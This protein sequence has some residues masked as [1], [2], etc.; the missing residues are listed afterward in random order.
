M[1]IDEPGVVAEITA[2]F[3]RYERALVDNDVAVL[4]AMF[5]P[6]ARTIRYG[7][8][9]IQHGMAEVAAFRLTQAGGLPRDLDRTVFCAFGRDFGT[10]TTLFRRPDAPGRLGRQTQVWARIDGWRI[11]HAHVSMIDELS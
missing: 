4:D 8:A 11:V 10:A 1:L 5:W 3:A 2:Q 9:D 7:I 6:D